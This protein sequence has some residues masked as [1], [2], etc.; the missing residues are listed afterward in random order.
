MAADLLQ[1]SSKSVMVVDD[2]SV[3]RQHA[4]GLFRQLGIKTIHEAGNGAQALR[5]LSEL[6][7]VPGLIVVDLE[8]PGM[9]GVEF[10]QQLVKRGISVP[11]LVASSK[12]RA[13]IGAVETMTDTLGLSVLGACQK[14]LSE[15]QLVEALHRLS[16]KPYFF[17]QRPRD[18][19][20]IVSVSELAAAISGHRLHPFY[21]PKVD[22]KTGLIKGVE[23]LARWQHAD[24]GFI[25]PEHFI[26]LAERHGLIHDLTWEI[27]GQAFAQAEA[28]GQRG[29]HLSIAI[30]LSQVLLDST[31][32]LQMVDYLL[33]QHLLPANQIV[34][35]VTEG[36]L[37]ADFGITLGNLARL[38]LKGFGLSIDDY[39]TG[40]ASMKQLSHIPF[41]ELKV[42]RSFVHGASQSEHLRVILQ[43]ALDMANR[44][45]LVT[46]GEGVETIEDWQLLQQFNCS[47]AQGYFVAKPMPGEDLPGWLK[48]NAIRL[49]SLHA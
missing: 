3:Q 18:A 46:V 45:N 26:E 31:D 25:S 35:E 24:K 36:M 34:W 21:Q 1:A 6:D 8:M 16:D 5:L 39:G 28:W 7:T 12:D 49:R 37:A 32:F 38:R 19:G 14:P 13:L 30:N 15:H 11:L 2:S 48:K 43:S 47:M 44:L 41:T 9:D 33:H 17:L 40:F 23:A 42:D 10:I 29:L 20:S 27:A 22:M 4:I